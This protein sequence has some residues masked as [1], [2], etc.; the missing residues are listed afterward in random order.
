WA[1]ADNRMFYPADQKTGEPSGRMVDG[2]WFAH[3]LD[4]R[5]ARELDAFP[6][7]HRV[8]QLYCLDSNRN[9]GLSV[10]FCDSR[11]VYCPD[12]IHQHSKTRK[13]GGKG[14]SV[15]GDPLYRAGKYQE[16]SNKTDT[17]GKTAPHGPCKF[18]TE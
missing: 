5:I 18:R 9:V 7:S 11:P 15:R 10:D 6:R 2:D 16:E 1:F 14:I 3:R 12:R 4:Y 8:F 17:W 13:K